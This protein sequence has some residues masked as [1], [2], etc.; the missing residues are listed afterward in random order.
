MKKKKRDH[1]LVFRGTDKPHQ[2]YTEL[3]VKSLKDNPAVAQGWTAVMLATIADSLEDIVDALERPR[4][5]R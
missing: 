1:T 5:R 3:V 2:T 4:S